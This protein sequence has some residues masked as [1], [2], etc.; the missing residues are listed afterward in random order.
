MLVDNSKFKKKYTSKFL[1][2]AVNLHDGKFNFFKKLSDW[3]ESCVQISDFCLTK[4]TSKAFVTLRA[5]DENDGD[6]RKTLKNK[7]KP[8]KNLRLV[9]LQSI[10]YNI[11]AD[12]FPVA[13]R[14]KNKLKLPKWERELKLGGQKKHRVV[15]GEGE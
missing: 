7:I 6:G 5:L 1:N 11:E 15:H 10:L 3:V 9:T 14:T 8:K 13:E 2:N 4:Q 12:C